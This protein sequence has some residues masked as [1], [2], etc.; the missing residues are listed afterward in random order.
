MAKIIIGFVGQLSSGKDVCKKYLMEKYGADSTRF[1]N[2]LRDILNRLYQPITR[3]NMQDV[4]LDLRNRFGSDILAR[5][6]AQDIRNSQTEI[7]I[8]DGVRRLD[9]IDCLKDLPGFYLISL[10]VEPKTRYERAVLRNEN[11]G[12]AEKTYEQF[13]IDGEREAEKEIPTVM[14]AAKYHINNNGGFDE[15]YAQLEKIMTEINK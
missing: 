13:L 9:D 4:S 12:D 1:S 6:V 2:V 14:A 15:L 3:E 5:V 10:E 8:V 7:M 11:V